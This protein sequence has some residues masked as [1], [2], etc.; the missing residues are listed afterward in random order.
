M[1]IHEANNANPAVK[2]NFKG[3]ILSAPY[4]DPLIQADYG[5]FLSSVGLIDE[6]AKKHFNEERLRFEELSAANEWVKVHTLMDELFHGDVTTYPTYFANVTGFQ[7]FLNYLQ[8]TFPPSFSHHRAF[9]RQPFVRSAIH[10]G[11]QKYHSF[12]KKVARSLKEDF[13]Q[14]SRSILE[15]L[16]DLEY[17]VL[18]ISAQ[19][20]MVCHAPGIYKLVH[21]LE[22]SG[23]EDFANS[24][25][26]VWKVNS[27]N[28]G[29]LKV[30]KNLAYLVMRNTGH[31]IP[32]D[33]PL[34]AST[35][36]NEFT[37]GFLFED[38]I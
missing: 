14:S 23:K 28:A 34:W 17:K 7:N 3:L 36:V 29:Y 13:H 5:P 35:L 27:E 37:S 30:A 21:A 8:P 25:R 9:L 24:S 15:K 18:V 11:S 38:Q 12:S 16:L 31:A 33:Q 2:I 6:K 4:V 22:W 19:L 20:D 10:V 1:R 32:H 26:V